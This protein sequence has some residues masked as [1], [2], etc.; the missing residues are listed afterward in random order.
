MLVSTLEAQR[1]KQ[2]VLI[3]DKKIKLDKTKPGAR[4]VVNASVDWEFRVLHGIS[5]QTKLG[6]RMVVNAFVDWE[7]RVLDGISIQ[8]KPGARMVV[9]ASMGWEF[10]RIWAFCW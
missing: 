2:G 10:W 3:A 4:M 9:N 7:F 6:A 1:S 5:I 8:T